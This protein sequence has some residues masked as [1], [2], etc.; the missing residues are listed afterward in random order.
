MKHSYKQIVLNMSEEELRDLLHGEYLRKLARY[1]LT[2][3]SLQRKYGLNFEEFEE[4]N[5]V[6]ENDFSWDVESDAQ[7]WEAAIDG[8]RTCLRKLEELKVGYR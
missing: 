8:I 4:R 5:I 7:E 6:A 2:D 3:E 1:R